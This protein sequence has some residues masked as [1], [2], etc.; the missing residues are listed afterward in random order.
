MYIEKVH[1]KEGRL[2]RLQFVEEY[3]VSIPIRCMTDIAAAGP[4]FFSPVSEQ[5]REW[6]FLGRY[7]DVC[8]ILMLESVMALCLVYGVAH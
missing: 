8:G 6:C 3:Q 4:E 2:V 7:V 1:T 5:L